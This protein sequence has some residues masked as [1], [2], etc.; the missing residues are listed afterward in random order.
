MKSNKFGEIILDEIDIVKL[1]YSGNLENLEKINIEDHDLVKRF[2]SAC[3]ENA[4]KFSKIKIY[5]EPSISIDEYDRSCQNNWFMPNSYQELDIEQYL[6]SKCVT[7]QEIDRVI[8][9]LLLFKKYNMM[10]VLKYLK[11][12]V[13]TLRDNN[14]VWGV[15]RGSSIASYCL[16]LLDVHRINSIKYNLDI[17]EFLK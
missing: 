8:N 11:Y 3:S 6:L 10:D 1:L 15:G 16:Y 14:I 9:E 7:E 17:E 13:D 4:D 2:N 5:Q 12:L